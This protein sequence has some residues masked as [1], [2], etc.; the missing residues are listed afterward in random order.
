MKR[1]FIKNP[2]PDFDCERNTYGILIRLG[3]GIY[4]GLGIRRLL[5]GHEEVFIKK[6]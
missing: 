1:F 6:N 3:L 4:L 5:E 2:G